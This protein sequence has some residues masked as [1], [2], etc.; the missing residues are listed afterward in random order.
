MRL[1]RAAVLAAVLLLR[2]GPALAQDVPLLAD[3]AEMATLFAADQA[4]RQNIDPARY[5]DR[6][7]VDQMIADDAARRMQARALL[8]A[9]ALQTAEDYRAAAFIFQHGSTPE[10]Y[11]LAHALAVTAVPKGS[12][13]ASWIAAASL[14]RFLQAVDRKQIYGT[15]TRMENGGEP[16]LEPY[17]RGLLPDSMRAAAGVPSVTEQDKRLEQFR[18]ARR[19][20]TPPQP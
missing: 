6:A 17:D 4:V 16:T 15:Q 9:G 12:Q 8:D 1:F 20:A 7:F 2:P 5:R 18:A 19:A 11:L 14:D 10:D 13:Q 3:N